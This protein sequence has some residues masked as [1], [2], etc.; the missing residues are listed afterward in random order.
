M[1]NS[2]AEANA[3]VMKTRRRLTR[4]ERYLQLLDLAW[5]LIREEGTDALSLGRLAET[6][7][8]TKPTVYE[9]FGTRH[10]LLTAL[11]QDFDSRHNKIIDEAIA[12]SK[13]ALEDK[14]YIIASSYIGCALSEGCEI[15]DVLAALNGSPELAE[16]RRK[17]QLDFLEKCRQSLAPF[18]GMKELSVAALWAMLGAAD[19]LSSVALSGEISEQQ[20]CNELYD[21]ILAM[22]HRTE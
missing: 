5:K 17:C 4:K 16:M 21:I 2:H 11:Y 10:G 22:V 14:A 20:A 13:P 19:A 1:S 6:A 18:L 9:H 3:E 15:P 7:G 8:I 12:A